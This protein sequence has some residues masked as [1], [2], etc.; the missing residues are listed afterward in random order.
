[1]PHVPSSTE[2][3][4]GARWTPSGMAL[5][6]ASIGP[7]A[8][9]SS[10]QLRIELEAGPPI[11]VK[12]EPCDV[13]K[14]NESTVVRCWR[15]PYAPKA[16]ETVRLRVNGIEC[17][18]ARVAP[19]PPQLDRPLRL[20]LGSCFHVNARTAERLSCTIEALPCSQKPD[21]QFL[22]GDQVY[23]D[24]S[25]RSD[26]HTQKAADL[27]RVSDVY[28]RTWW[29]KAGLSRLLQTAPTVF[30]P[31][32]HDIWNE[33]RKDHVPDDRMG[34][35]RLALELLDAV[36][37]REC[38][39]AFDVAPLSFLVLDTRRERTKAEFVSSDVLERTLTWL[40][41]LK[42]PGVL[43]TGQPLFG[44]PWRPFRI[45]LG[46]DLSDRRFRSQYA[47]LAAAISSAPHSIVLLS[48]DV[49]WG[50]VASATEPG[51]NTAQVVEVIA[52]PLALHSRWSRI[53]RNWVKAPR[54][55]P[56]GE[57][58]S[59]ASELIIDTDP[60]YQV[61][62]DH[63]A[64]IEFRPRPDDIEMSVTAHATDGSGQTRAA[65]VLLR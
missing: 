48:G 17:D 32:D 64:L 30:C 59:G 54:R 50:R 65:P 41:K 53:P 2:F 29:G 4:I 28:R 43:V 47:A 6:I 46:S 34:W 42:G 13:V 44:E 55:F 15:V 5:W 51:K 35:H 38:W 9:P 33:Y 61:R 24:R 62:A 63:F 7:S 26:R 3:T 36:Q 10:H 23:L 31:D 27:S 58:A 60:N 21:L 49:H 1:M 16:A 39:Q 11:D 12:D 37:T 56:R 25:Q 14:A 20:L 52:S 40:A 45:R 18:T 19:L 8:A 57:L 22:C